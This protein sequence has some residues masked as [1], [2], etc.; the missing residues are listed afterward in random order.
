MA[1]SRPPGPRPPAPVLPG[2][3]RRVR[4]ALTFL[5]LRVGDLQVAVGG[6]QLLPP[7]D[8]LLQVA[9]GDVQAIE[10]D[11]VVLE[12]GREFIVHT[13]HGAKG[14]LRFSEETWTRSMYV[15]L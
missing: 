3:G 14:S 9:E 12:F 4:L 13:G 6:L 8:L 11:G 7:H 2:P 5:R 15:Y 1:V 10:G